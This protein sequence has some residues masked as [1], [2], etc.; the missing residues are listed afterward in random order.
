MS[1]NGDKPGR[2]VPDLGAVCQKLAEALKGWAK[3]LG[4]EAGH[5]DAR[6][7]EGS[8]NDWGD[9]LRKDTEDDTKTAVSLLTARG[10]VDV[11]AD[12]RQRFENLHAQAQAYQ[13]R[14]EA[15]EDQR[16][17][18]VEG[19]VAQYRR[20]FDDDPD[21]TRLRALC[22]GPRRV[23][24]LR[25]DDESRLETAEQFAE[26]IDKASW[27]EQGGKL[28]AQAEMQRAALD[29]AEHIEV[30]L[31]VTENP[32][33]Q[34]EDQPKQALPKRGKRGP[35]RM[36]LAEAWRYLTVVQEW[37]GIQESNRKLPLRD[38]VQKVQL[39]EKHRIT[40]QEV[41][42]MLAWYAKH[43]RERRFPKDPRT[44]SRDELEKWFE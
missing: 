16:R 24:T 41:D 14:L 39:A 20:K 13:Q 42:A 29:L 26:A 31:A 35:S 27:E 38:R 32:T 5:Y 19:L 36:P 17:V 3:G 12:L 15:L 37:A 7:E 44:L 22:H 23:W 2:F 18:H 25:G 30:L 10:R 34:Q 1:G 33:A 11:A 4:T 43:L 21:Q 8:S 9:Q 6:I 40:V 28:R